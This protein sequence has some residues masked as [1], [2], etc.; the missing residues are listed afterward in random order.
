M[1]KEQFDNLKK[2]Q[3]V[4]I[5]ARVEQKNDEHQTIRTNIPGVTS[6]IPKERL[7]PVGLHLMEEVLDNMPEWHK[8][9]F[10]DAIAICSH[11]HSKTPLPDEK[12]IPFT[13]CIWRTISADYPFSVAGNDEEIEECINYYSVAFRHYL[14]A[15]LRT[16]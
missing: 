5:I 14:T 1:H 7:Q 8:S 12:L 6:W 15:L 13:L 16:K 4:A 9:D 10:K 2:G 3:H 11:I